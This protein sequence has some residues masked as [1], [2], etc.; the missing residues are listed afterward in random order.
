VDAARDLGG[1]LRPT[2]RGRA[3]VAAALGATLGLTDGAAAGAPPVVPWQQALAHV[4]RVVTVEGRVV[5]VR[6]TGDAWVLE[7]GHTETALRV[8]LLV[9]L[10][11]ALPPDPEG[12]YRG[13]R[14]RATGRLQRFR[15]RPEMVLRNPDRIVLLDPTPRPAPPTPTAAGTTAAD[16]P[17]G[18]ADACETGRAR[19]RATATAVHARARA[20]GRCLDDR[21]YACR[22]EAAALEPALASLAE[23]EAAL[24][25]A[26]P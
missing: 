10:R 19:W 22:A 23:A 13:R 26:C 2:R 12:H 1:G 6:P 5:A 7:F 16:P 24:D 9:P 4:G 25:A 3:V 15:G 20:L 17:S 11:A 21:P 8:M 14:I 18:A